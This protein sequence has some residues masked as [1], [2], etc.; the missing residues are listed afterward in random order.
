MGY[1]N[2]RCACPSENIKPSFIKLR[3]SKNEKNN[4]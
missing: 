4:L 3:V 2:K 1:K